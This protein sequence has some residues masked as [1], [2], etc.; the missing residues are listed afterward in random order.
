MARAVKDTMP[1][2]AFSTFAANV[3]AFMR[4]RVFEIYI[5]LMSLGVGA[6]ILVY[7]RWTRK[8]QQVRGLLRFWSRNFIYGARVI[9]GIRWKIEVV[10]TLFFFSSQ[11]FAH[12][13]GPVKGNGGLEAEQARQAT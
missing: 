6:L 8:P 1:G 4:T 7:Y 10:L 9:L 11:R 3:L 13:A 12:S 2:S 5:L